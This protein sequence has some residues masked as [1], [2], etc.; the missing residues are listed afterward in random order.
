VEINTS[1]LETDIVFPVWT[2][3]GKNVDP[4]QTSSVLPLSAISKSLSAQMEASDQ[5][6]T[7]EDEKVN[8][9]NFYPD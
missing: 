3:V 4:I 2:F 8:Q 9:A 7:R 6:T 1:S 5:Q